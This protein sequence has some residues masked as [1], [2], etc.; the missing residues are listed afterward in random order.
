MPKNT[1]NTGPGEFVS[2]A[3]DLANDENRVEFYRKWAAD[4]DHQMLDRLGYTS[5]QTIAN[6]LIKH[7]SDRS[8]PIIDIG[9]GTGLTCTL[10]HQNG[11]CRL[12][13]IDFSADMLKVAS[14]RNIYQTLIQGDLN[15]P[16]N[17]DS[18][19]YHAAISS[20][21]FTHGHIGPEPLDEIVRIVKPGGLLA[22]TVHRDL[23]QSAGFEA[24]LNSLEWSNTIECL[25]L[26]EGAYFA[27]SDIDG[28]FCVYRKCAD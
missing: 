6:K 16:L 25:E 9:C 21:I 26:T 1:S 5:P 27:N 8:A 28:W 13:G 24:K 4:Y 3:Y 12:D 15:Q 20:G 14:N 17:I 7:L 11:Y 22:I 2:Q 18:N 23:W 19:T 10:L